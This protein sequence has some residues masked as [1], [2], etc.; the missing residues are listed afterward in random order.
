MLNCILLQDTKQ[1]VLKLSNFLERPLSKTDLDDISRRS[2]FGEMS[3]NRK[4]NNDLMN[5][6]IFKK[7][8]NANLKFMRKGI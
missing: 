7:R 8:D 5:N 2:E 6:P 1:T 3:K 4:A